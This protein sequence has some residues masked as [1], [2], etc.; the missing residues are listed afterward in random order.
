M[1]LLRVMAKV[2]NPHGRSSHQAQTGPPP[3]APLSGEGTKPWHLADHHTTPPPCHDS[4]QF[5]YEER[6]HHCASGSNIINV[7]SF[8][9]A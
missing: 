4:E 5:L 6:R 2:L 7:F 8:S 1:R 9:K 3:P